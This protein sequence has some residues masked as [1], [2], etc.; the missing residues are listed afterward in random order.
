MDVVALKL[1]LPLPE[2]NKTNSNIFKS[3][4]IIIDIKSKTI[5]PNKETGGRLLGKR[6][7]EGVLGQVLTVIKKETITKV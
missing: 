1:D 3:V 7:V 2:K 6:L 4:V 5:N